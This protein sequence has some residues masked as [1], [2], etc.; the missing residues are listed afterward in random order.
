MN[1]RTSPSR[2][3]DGSWAG[4]LGLTGGDGQAAWLG[5]RDDAAVLCLC[6]PGGHLT[7]PLPPSRAAGGFLCSDLGLTCRLSPGGLEGLLT[8]G[9]TEP[10]GGEASGSAVP[11]VAMP[12][13]GHS[14]VDR[15]LRWQ[16]SLAG[17]GG[18]RPLRAGR[19]LA[20][21]TCRGLAVP[22]LPGH[23][24][25]GLEPGT[26]GPT[27]LAPHPVLSGHLRSP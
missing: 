7:L 6:F 2:C 24:H 22:A 26:R 15:S 25:G 1:G 9:E 17:V 19:K 11:T 20:G 18:A 13:Q 21:D 3:R 16:Q 12:H 27:P 5:S 23:E 14:G 8:P 4:R 10:S